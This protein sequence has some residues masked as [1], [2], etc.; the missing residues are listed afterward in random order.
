VLRLQK[1]I[2]QVWFSGSDRFQEM[3]IKYEH[4]HKIRI[5][6]RRKKVIP[7]VRIII[8]LGQLLKQRG[9]PPS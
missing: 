3:K 6:G 8:D 9:R 5:K 4:F 1:H 2:R 7:T